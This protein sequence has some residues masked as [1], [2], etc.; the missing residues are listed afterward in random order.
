MPREAAAGVVRMPDSDGYDGQFYR[1]IARDPF[2]LK[3]WERY[4]DDARLR[5]RRILV[6]VLAWTLAMGRERYIDCAFLICIWASVLLGV[7][8]TGMWFAQQ[9]RSA[10]WGA[11]FLLVPATLTSIDRMLLDGPLCTLF[12]GF[13]CQASRGRRPWTILLCAPLLKETGSLLGMGVWLEAIRSKR[14]RQAAAASATQV[15]A[16]FWFAFVQIHT[17]PSRA[18]VVLSLPVAGH[19]ERLFT[20]RSYSLPRQGELLLQISDAVAVVSLLASAGIGL[21][22]LWPYKD[23]V[24]ISTVLFILMGLVLGGQ[25]YLR[26]AY[27]FARPISPFLWALLVRGIAERRLPAALATLGLTASVGLSLAYEMVLV[28]RRL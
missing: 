6:P 25:P 15:P 10:I 14:W 3:G 1:L 20:P 27:G 22:W 24:E 8:W 7:Y 18:D 13:V 16:L 11:S 12:A 19:M 17:P 26:E 4:I 9:G 2:F 23:A 5:Y 28:L 21:V